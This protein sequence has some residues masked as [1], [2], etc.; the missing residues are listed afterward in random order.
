M[1]ESLHSDEKTA[2]VIFIAGPFVDL[3]IDLL[4]A[5]KIEVSDRKICA[6][7]NG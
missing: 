1:W 5:S 3:A 4:P 6:S 7:R 2:S